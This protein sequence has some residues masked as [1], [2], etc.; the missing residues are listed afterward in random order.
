MAFDLHKLARA[1]EF[2]MPVGPLGLVRCKSFTSDLMLEAR[3]RL[4][5]HKPEGKEFARWLLGELAKLPAVQDFHESD[6]IQ[7]DSLTAEQ[8]AFV[9]DFEL[10]S[11]CENILKKN[12]Y[13]TREHGSKDFLRVE[14][15]SACDFLAQA[16]VHRG[17]EEKAQIDRIIQSAT[18]PLFTVSTIDSIK[19]NLS[20]SNDFEDLIKKYSAKSSLDAIRESI[21]ASN[22]LDALG[23]QYLGDQSRTERLLAQTQPEPEFVNVPP[24]RFPKN[25]IHETNQILEN[26]TSQIEDMRPLVAQGAELIRSMNDTALRMQADYFRNAERT[27]TQTKNALRVAV[28]SLIVSAVSLFASSW[29]SYQT[30]ADG[31]MAASESKEQGRAFEERFNKLLAAQ[32]EDRV[33]LIKALADLKQPESAGKK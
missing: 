7:G 23:K 29:F 9:T 22:P 5:V 27:D 3:Q 18:E 1:A 4:N 31:K 10:E 12:L 8:L 30:Y 15:Q 28:F 13:L 20:A 14:G 24:M 32:H 6:P 26:L 21:A 11:F 17:N 33:L 2:S 16:I 25:P 19:K